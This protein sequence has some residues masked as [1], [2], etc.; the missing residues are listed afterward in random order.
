[1]DPLLAFG[2]WAF[3][4]TFAGIYAIFVLG[5]QVEVGDTGLVNFGHVA[6][7]AIGAYSMGLMLTNDWPVGLAVPLAVLAAVAGGVLLGIPTLRLRADYFAITTIAAGEIL[8]IAIQN[9]QETTGG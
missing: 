8:R 9:E 4:L 3:V 1:M 6:F 2:F 7:M 5:L